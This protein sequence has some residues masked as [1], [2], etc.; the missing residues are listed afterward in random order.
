MLSPTRWVALRPAPVSTSTVV[1]SGSRLASRRMLSAAAALARVNNLGPVRASSPSAAS[2]PLCDTATALPPDRRTAANPS[3]VRPGFVIEAPSA[4]VGCT[5]RLPAR[6][7]RSGKLLAEARSLGWQRAAL[8][9]PRRNSSQKPMSLTVTSLDG[10]IR[11]NRSRRPRRCRAPVARL[12]G[13]GREA[14]A[15]ASPRPQA[16]RGQVDSHRR[17][18][19]DYVR[20]KA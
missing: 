12:G 14:G 17:R 15:R 18:A 16:R 13:M 1:S 7:R 8:I 4:M 20:V 6:R 2:M 5:Q 11:P 3:R 19:G 10:R 9:S